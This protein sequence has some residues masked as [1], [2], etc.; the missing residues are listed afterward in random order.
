MTKRK[1]ILTKSREHRVVEK[2]KNYYF[3]PTANRDYV[4]TTNS[5]MASSN[6][7]VG[8]VI[9]T[10]TVAEEKF[11]CAEKHDANMED[12][13]VEKKSDDDIQENDSLSDTDSETGKLVI[14][15]KCIEYENENE[16]ENEIQK[17]FQVSRNRS[18]I[19]STNIFESLSVSPVD[20][21]EIRSTDCRLSPNEVINA[22]KSITSSP[23]NSLKSDNPN[24]GSEIVITV[25]DDG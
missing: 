18:T 15:E 6:M 22:S 4:S 1:L 7:V 12:V 19:D 24:Y 3:R 21:F 14:D 10:S 2:K 8:G 11:D 23:S 17:I 5:S 20:A 13:E 16:R 9:D 25:D